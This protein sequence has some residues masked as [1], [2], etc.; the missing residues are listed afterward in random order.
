MG[1]NQWW[2]KTGD[3][4]TFPQDRGSAPFPQGKKQN[5][6]QPFSLIIFF[7]TFA[8]SEIHFGPTM[9]HN[10]FSYFLFLFIYIFSG[11]ATGFD[12]TKKT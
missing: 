7:W 3:M 10:L 2:H 6:N 9:P 12:Q 4:G 1:F 8:P 5:K 11:I